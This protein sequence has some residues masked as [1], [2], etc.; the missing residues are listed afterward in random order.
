MLV[1]SRKVSEEIVIGGDIVITVVAV[2]G[3]LVRLGISAPE[4]VAILRRELC[5]EA[6]PAAAQ[7]SENAEAVM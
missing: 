7:A 3:K 5:F 4:H 6:P 1:L 2:K